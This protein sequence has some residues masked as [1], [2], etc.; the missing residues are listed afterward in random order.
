MKGCYVYFVDKEVE[1]YFKKNIEEK[2]KWNVTNGIIA[3]GIF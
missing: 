3:I 2:I 1:N